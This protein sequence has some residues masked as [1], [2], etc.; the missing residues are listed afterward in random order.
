MLESKAAENHVLTIEEAA[1]YLRVNPQT[2]YRHLR[3]GSLPGAKIGRTWRIRR[4]DLNRLLAGQTSTEE[5]S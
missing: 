5:L 2:V 1:E 3:A 4:V